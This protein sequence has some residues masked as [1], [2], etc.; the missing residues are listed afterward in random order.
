VTTY[1]LGDGIPLRFLATDRDGTAVDTTMSLAVLSLATGTQVATPA[2]T[3]TATGQYDATATGLAIGDY[4]YVWTATGTISDVATGTFTVA[5]TGPATYTNLPAVKGN[6]GKITNDDRDENIALAIVA[7]S[8]MIDAAT[9]RPAGGFQADLVVSARTFPISG[10]LIQP[11][12]TDMHRR[13]AGVPGRQRVAIL[14]D[15]IAT[16]TGLLVEAGNRGAATYNTITGPISGPDNALAK[17]EPIE[18]L[19]LPY[20]AL[21]GTIDSIRVTARWGWPSIPAEVEMATRLLAS[22]LYKRKDSPQGVITSSDWGAVRVS[23][24][25]PDV[26]ALIHHLSIPGFA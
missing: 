1:D 5:T 14:V 7:A 19:S 22:R 6:L 8:R 10:R 24:T 13:F 21:L 25:D 11:S 2:I 26:Y 3:H 20:T 18:W 23:K 9:G 15:D 16:E 17:G 4:A 12:G